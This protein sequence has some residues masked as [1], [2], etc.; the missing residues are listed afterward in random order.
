MKG[1]S[2][3]IGKLSRCTSVRNKDMQWVNK[4]IRVNPNK[5]K[6]KSLTA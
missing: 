4:H 3:V 1:N 5:Q 6:L 2:F